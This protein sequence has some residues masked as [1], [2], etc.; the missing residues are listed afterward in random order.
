MSRK[1]KRELED[2]QAGVKY[3][4]IHHTKKAKAEDE[5]ETILPEKESEQ[6]K[7]KKMISNLIPNLLSCPT[8]LH[9]I[10]APKK[11]VGFFPSLFV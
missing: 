7:K 6:K 5:G 9:L 10:I 2:L 11:I 4:K 3:H 8:H 1:H